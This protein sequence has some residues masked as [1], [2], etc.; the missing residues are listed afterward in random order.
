MTQHTPSPQL[1]FHDVGQI[2]PSRLPSPHIP[3]IPSSHYQQ[4]HYRLHPTNPVPNLPPLQFSQLRG[5]Q[6]TGNATAMAETY[7]QTYM[8]NPQHPQMQLHNQNPELHHQIYTSSQSQGPTQPRD[9][10]SDRT[11]VDPQQLALGY[12]SGYYGPPMHLGPADVHR[13]SN[14]EWS[15]QQVVCDTNGNRVFAGRRIGPQGPQ[16]IPERNLVGS[17]GWSM[18][19]SDMPCSGMLPGPSTDSKLPLLTSK[20]SQIERTVATWLRKSKTPL[21]DSAIEE[22]AR[23]FAGKSGDETDR[24]L[25]NSPGWLEKFKQRNGIATS[26][27]VSSVVDQARVW[28]P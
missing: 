19:S 21:A 5:L 18:N 22:K 28:K 1:L 8:N 16:I 9:S 7:P 6:S 10:N 24:L 15:S 2:A 26:P 3:Q 12:S 27:S 14:S 13:N 11:S 25:I 17:D 23:Y 4:P 20:L